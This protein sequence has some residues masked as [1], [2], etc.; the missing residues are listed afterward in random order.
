MSRRCSTADC[1]QPGLIYV[2]KGRFV[3]LAHAAQLRAEIAASAAM[4]NPAS[5]ADIDRAAEQGRNTHDFSDVF[6]ALRDPL[7]LQQH[8]EW[9]GEADRQRAAERDEALRKQFLEE[10]ERKRK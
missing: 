6:P 4:A 2:R 5:I 7:V 8:V 10:Q 3:C 9:W 1:E